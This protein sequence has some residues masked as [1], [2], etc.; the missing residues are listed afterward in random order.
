MNS[1]VENRISVYPEM[2]RVTFL[3]IR[4]L[5]LRLA[6]DNDLGDIEET[7]KWGQPSYLCKSGSTIRVDWQHKNPDNMGVFFNCNTVLV[8]TFREIFPEDLVYRGNRVVE[9]PLGKPLPNELEPCL[10]MALNYHKLKKLPLLG[11]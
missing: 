1:L 6:R 5:I 11:A 9:I 8:E 3:R 10:L 4:E 7:L 2:A